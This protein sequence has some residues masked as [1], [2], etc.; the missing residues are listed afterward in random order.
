MSEKIHRIPGQ[1]DWWPCIGTSCQLYTE[2]GEVTVAAPKPAGRGEKCAF[3]Y[4]RG[5]RCNEYADHTVHHPQFIL[6]HD[7]TV[8]G[9]DKCHKC[10]QTLGPGEVHWFDCAHSKCKDGCVCGCHITNPDP[11]I[12]IAFEIAE[13]DRRYGYGCID[14]HEAMERLHAEIYRRSNKGA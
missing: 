5:G 2:H 10:N 12:K 14:M 3:V 8:A 7:F 11:L 4:E 1:R 9:P 13:I 6:R